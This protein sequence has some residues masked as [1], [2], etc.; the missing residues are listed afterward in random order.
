MVRGVDSIPWAMRL[1]VISGVGISRLGQILPDQFKWEAL[2][3][4]NRR[5]IEAWQCT[6]VS[7]RR[8]STCLEF[9]CNVLL[10]AY[11][12]LHLFLNACALSVLRFRPIAFA[13]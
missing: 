9:V 5:A 2:S 4:K 13:K 1:R 3:E 6:E 11:G 10:A 8:Q 7:K 12:S